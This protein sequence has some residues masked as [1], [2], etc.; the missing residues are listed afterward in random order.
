M[1]FRICQIQVSLVALNISLSCEIGIQVC[2]KCILQGVW[3]ELNKKYV[4]AENLR[5]NIRD[6]SMKS[7]KADFNMK[8][9]R[10]DF[11]QYPNFKTVLDD[12]FKF[13]NLLS[14]TS[15]DHRKATWRFP[16]G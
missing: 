2:R 14:L 3:T 13:P 7:S 5:Q 10:V 9:V 15:Y 12:F 16:F 6:K 11:P 1:P 4:S 8:S